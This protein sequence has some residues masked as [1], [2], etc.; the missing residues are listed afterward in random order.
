LVFS[1]PAEAVNILRPLPSQNIIQDFDQLV[2]S[3][4]P[5]LRKDATGFIQVVRELMPESP[6]RKRLV[7]KGC[8]Y[9][10]PADAFCTL[11]TL[12][13]VNGLEAPAAILLGMDRLLES[14]PDLRLSA[15]D[16]AGQRLVVLRSVR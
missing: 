6:G 15:G 3:V 13:A 14:E 1:H 4:V 16:R 11:T 8:N 2:R 9:W 5:S 10:P 7:W 12:N